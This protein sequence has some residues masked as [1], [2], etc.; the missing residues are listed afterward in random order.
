MKK[1]YLQIKELLDKYNISCSI[2]LKK[3]FNNF[4]NKLSYVYEIYISDRCLNDVHFFEG[5]SF[6][7]CIEKLKEALKKKGKIQNLYYIQLHRNETLIGI[8]RRITKKKFNELKK[9]D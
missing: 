6:D 8:K 7:K 4:N 2:S 3:Q 9:E 5:K 1:F